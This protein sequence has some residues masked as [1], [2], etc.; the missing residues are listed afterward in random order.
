MKEI[1]IDF[2]E[3]GEPTIQVAGVNGP[4]CK[5]LTAVLEKALGTVMQDK[6]TPEYHRRQ[7]QKVRQ[8]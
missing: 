2:D 8:G 4:G 6:L 5:S 1:T 7:Q 3:Q